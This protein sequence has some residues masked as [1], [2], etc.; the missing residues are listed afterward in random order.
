M[1]ATVSGMDQTKTELATRE[2]TLAEARKQVEGLISDALSNSTTP[3]DGVHP[4]TTL[5]ESSPPAPNPTAVDTTPL[6]D[7]LEPITT[8][9]ATIERES[10]IH[11]LR[12]RFGDIDEQAVRA[13][14]DAVSG[15]SAEGALTMVVGTQTLH[16]RS[17]AAGEQAAT[18]VGE[19]ARTETTANAGV[20]PTETIDVSSTPWEGLE[21]VALR[22][23]GSRGERLLVP[24]R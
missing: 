13:T 3:P 15:I 7:V 8:R 11:S 18:R 16:D 12:Q 5:E 1:V 10:A 21:R 9:I 22:V 4:N 17:A 23:M 2:R 19:A 14:M 6:T 20:V 24:R